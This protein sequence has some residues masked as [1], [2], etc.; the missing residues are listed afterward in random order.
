MY[1]RAGINP[2]PADK[3]VFTVLGAI[4]GDIIGSVYEW[5]N[6]KTKDFELFS[7]RCFFTDDTVMTLAVA[8][9]CF[10]WLETKDTEEFK[11]SV[12]SE[13]QRLGREYPNRGYGGMFSKWLLSKNPKPYNSFGNGSAMRVS[14][15]AYAADTLEEA[16]LLA[17]ASAEVTHSHP[18]GIKG[19]QAAAAAMFLA[20]DGKSMSE[21]KS[22]IDEHY[23]TLDFTLDEIRSD[24]AFDETCQGSVPQA[25]AAFFESTGYEDAVRNAISIGGDS[26]TIACITGGIAE[27]FYGIP[28]EIQKEGFKYFADEPLLDIYRRFWERVRGA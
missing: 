13:M 20:R 22:Y 24:Y 10:V 14:P 28:E 12:V 21:I 11:N 4:F 18:E 26:D 8:E 27:A 9:A 2:C 19:A 23:Y 1:V 3:E 16:E 6:I 15:V 5:N 17:K 25:L 7:P